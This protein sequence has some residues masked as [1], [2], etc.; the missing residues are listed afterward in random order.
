MSSGAF[1]PTPIRVE[2]LFELS[3]SVPVF[4]V[5]TP[6]EHA[7]ARIPGAVN[8]PLFSNEERAEIGT[9][10]KRA[11][12]DAAMVRG[13]DL[14][15][16]RL[17]TL[18]EGVRVR[19]A[20]DTVVVHCWRGGMRSRSVAWLLAFFGYRVF[21]LDGGYK[22][23]RR[24]ALKLLERPIHP[25][26][27]SGMTGVGKTGVLRALGEQGEQIVDLEALARHKGSVFGGIGQGEQPSQELFE[28]TL[29]VA[30]DG[31]DPVRPIWFEDESRLI[32]RRVIPAPIWARLQA[33]PSVVLEA[34]AER[35]AAA[36][37]DEYGALSATELDAAIDR[38]RRRL[39][40]LRTRE[41]RAALARGD[42]EETCRVLLTYYDRA[43]AKCAADRAPVVLLRM[44]RGDANDRETARRV[45][46]ALADPIRGDRAP[47]AAP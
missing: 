37:V 16:P 29:A 21:V 30:L 47:V 6:A 12:R 35:R 44:A 17:R 38:L 15:G 25:V 22:A 46:K 33:A 9:L 24:H 10:Y 20:A 26:V 43:Y 13:L 42:L 19:T 5:R 28:N 8:L 11:G 27:L 39:G 1:D 41:A 3:D 2:A 18:V 31:L 34:P 36:L 4:D 40:G 32:G 23:F 7:H 14:V 45:R